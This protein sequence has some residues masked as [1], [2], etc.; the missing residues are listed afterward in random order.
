M[1]GNQQ[2]FSTI[3]FRDRVRRVKEQMNA[4]GI[5]VLLVHSPENIYYLTGHQTSGY[6]A[7][8]V[9][10]LSQKAEPQLL[11]RYLERGNVDEYSW[12]TEAATWKEGEDVVAKTLDLARAAGAAGKTVGLEK[13]CWFLTAAVA[14]AL[15]AGLSSSRIVDASMLVDRIR[16]IKSETE[17]RYLRQA[18]TIAE[19]EQRAA[20]VAITDGATEAQ[21][22]AAVYQAGVLAGCE[23]TGLPHHIMSG[24][25]Y[26]VCHANWSP[27]VVRRGELILLELYGCV[28]RYHS[29]QMRTISIGP[30]SKEVAQAAEIVIAA[31]DAAF[32][33]MRPGASAREV[34]ALVR[35]PIRKIRPDYFNRSGY[36]T[37]IGFPPRTGEWEAL[38]F[39]EQ[40]DWELKEGMVFHML[41]L[42]HG[43]GISETVVVAKTGIENLTPSNPRAL[44]VK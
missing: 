25:R 24:Y 31:Q 37:G 38:D 44:I 39:N 13:R 34:D 1:K 28:E 19:K 20:L 27:K 6:F 40:Q 10:I 36:S 15:V 35:K 41:A 18:G 16:L 43:F 42:A 22:A 32:A 9:L 4:D 23:Y 29:T 12:L 21:I 7:Y 3:E 30:P 14:E 2:A 11:L 5:D 17:V 26:N 33:A 8:Q